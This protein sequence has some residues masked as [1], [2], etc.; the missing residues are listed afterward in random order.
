MITI[1]DT[2]KTKKDYHYSLNSD[3]IHQNSTMNGCILTCDIDGCNRG[4]SL[5]ETFGNLPHNPDCHLTLTRVSTT[6]FYVQSP[7]NLI[8]PRLIPFNL[9]V[10]DLNILKYFLYIKAPIILLPSLNLVSPSPDWITDLRC[11]FPDL[12]KPD[13]EQHMR[14][15]INSETRNKPKQNLR[16]VLLFKSEFSEQECLQRVHA[17]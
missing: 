13:A 16:N 14:H 2:N 11:F 9:S 12:H 8:Q 7:F 10:K 6:F 3:F 5:E 4:S 17:S 1:I 15:V